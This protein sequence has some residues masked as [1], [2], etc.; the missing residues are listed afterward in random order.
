MENTKSKDLKEVMTMQ[1]PK[2]KYLV[3]GIIFLMIMCTS[4]IIFSYKPKTSKYTKAKLVLELSPPVQM[5]G[6]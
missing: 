6:M 1:L 5:I 4:W 2:K 3:L